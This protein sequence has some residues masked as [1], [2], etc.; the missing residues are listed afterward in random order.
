MDEWKVVEGPKATNLWIKTTKNSTNREIDR[1]PFVAIFG[2]N[3][4]ISQEQEKFWG[5]RGVKSVSTFALI[6]YD[7]GLVLLGGPIFTD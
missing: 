2:E 5:K 3:F 7:A 4:R 6:P 1:I